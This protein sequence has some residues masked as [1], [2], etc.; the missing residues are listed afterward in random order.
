MTRT[1]KIRN[2]QISKTKMLSFMRYVDVFRRLFN[3]E[4]IET[5]KTSA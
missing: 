1:T 2:L 5:R 4:D 3:Q